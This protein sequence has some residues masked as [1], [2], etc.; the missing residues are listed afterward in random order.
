MSAWSRTIPNYIQEVLKDEELNQ[1][2]EYLNDLIAREEASA[3]TNRI[4][5][6]L[7]DLHGLA[8]SVSK[9]SITDNQAIEIKNALQEVEKEINKIVGN[10]FLRI[11][12]CRIKK[13]LFSAK[14][15]SNVEHDK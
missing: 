11:I 9:Y 5:S 4:E 13:L 1:L 6:A 14:R 15:F 3:E 8:K 2:Q 10:K 7:S 12:S